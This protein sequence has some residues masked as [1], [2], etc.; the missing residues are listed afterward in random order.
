MRKT[1]QVKFLGL[2]YFHNSITISSYAKARWCHFLINTLL[3]TRYNQCT[4]FG[5]QA[6]GTDNY[7][8]SN[9]LVGF[10]L[11]C[12]DAH[13]PQIESCS[14]GPQRREHVTLY[15]QQSCF[16]NSNKLN[17][18]SWVKVVMITI[19]TCQHHVGQRRHYYCQ[20][21]VYTWMGIFSTSLHHHAFWFLCWG[22]SPAKNSY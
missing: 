4:S 7:Y 6:T 18:E 3:T 17:G 8:H 13:P 20:L 9:R 21:A 15:K 22:T 14:H 12:T 11:T 2:Q 1:S 10:V 19:H 5:S 16:M